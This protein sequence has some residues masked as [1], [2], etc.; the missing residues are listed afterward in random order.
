MKVEGREA[1]VRGQRLAD[2]ADRGLEWV[3]RRD[4]SLCRTFATKVL[5]S[6][7]ENI[8]GER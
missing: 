4:E 8:R 3:G 7:H 1:L 5:R 6:Q 2:A